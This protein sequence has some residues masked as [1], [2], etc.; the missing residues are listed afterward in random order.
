MKARNL[1]IVALLAT[2]ARGASAQPSPALQ[3]ADTWAAFGWHHTDVPDDAFTYGGRTNRVVGTVGGGWY[4]S[5]YLKTEVDTG[6]P[7]RTTFYRIEPVTIGNVTV[8]RY[9]RI[10]ERSWTFAAVQ[11][12]EFL[13]NAWFTPYIG[14]GVAA[15]RRTREEYVESV[16][17]VDPVSRRPL[18]TE[19]EGRGT[20]V[21][22]LAALGFKAY[23]SRRVFFRTETRLAFRSGVDHSLVRFGFGVDF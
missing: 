16:F 2:C 9:S 20:V 7:V 12:V 17:P 6:T 21:R 22:P 14:A 3:R 8:S 15:T 11:I 1:L 23:L 4:W 19:T 10:A 18:E 13:P 5:P